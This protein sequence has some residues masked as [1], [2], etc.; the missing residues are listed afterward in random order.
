M[1]FCYVKYFPC[2]FWLENLPLKVFDYPELE[3]EV[4]IK[5][6][7]EGGGRD[8]VTYVTQYNIYLNKNKQTLYNQYIYIILILKIKKIW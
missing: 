2:V 5:I 8:C 3:S 1:H 4:R 7:C 6:P